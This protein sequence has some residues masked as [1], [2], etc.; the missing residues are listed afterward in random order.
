MASDKDL[1][2]LLEGA[3]A[4]V[5]C[6]ENSLPPKGMLYGHPGTRKTVTACAAAGQG[7][8]VLLL[9]SGDGGEISLNNHPEI[10][11]GVDVLQLQGLTHLKAVGLGI[12]AG[13]EAYSGYDL[14]VVDTI[15]QLADNFLES[16]V[17]NCVDSSGPGGTNGRPVSKARRGV[18]GEEDI[19]TEGMNDYKL[20]ARQMR[21]L[22][23]IWKDVPTQVIWL[24]HEREPSFLAKK[25]QDL[26]TPDLPGKAFTELAEQM[27]YIGKLTVTERG[28]GYINFSSNSMQIGKSRISGLNGKM[29]TEKFWPALLG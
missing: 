11:A 23:S 28:Q 27:T 12:K 19:E 16:R 5:S 8:R 25:N 22:M 10:K 15:S 20:L 1:L 26:C 13:L 18:E 6:G 14:V 29:E 3:S 24:A 2:K 4:P 9:S 7:K 21:A 17:A